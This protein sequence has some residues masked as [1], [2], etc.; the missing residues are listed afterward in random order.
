MS[1]GTPPV[2]S[3]GVFLAAD[4]E[5]WGCFRG[6]S[7]NFPGHRSA[8]G[9]ARRQWPGKDQPE[10]MGGAA[11]RMALGRWRP[12]PPPARSRKKRRSTR[13]TPRGNSPGNLG[14]KMRLRT[15]RGFGPRRW[16]RGAWGKSAEAV[17]WSR[18]GS[19]RLSRVFIFSGLSEGQA[20]RPPDG[21]ASRRM[22]LLSKSQVH[23]TKVQAGSGEGLNALPHSR[24]EASRYEDVSGQGTPACCPLARRASRAL[25]EGLNAASSVS[26]GAISKTRSL[27]R[28]GGFAPHRTGKL[29]A[30][31]PR[32]HPGFELV[33]KGIGRRP[34]NPPPTPPRNTNQ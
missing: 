17:L 7:A 8:A 9:E 25:P 12:T 29:D 13:L 11:A 27:H 26:R 15:C 20:S 28:E 31:F 18:H 33:E 21:V 32:P 19:G 16:W 3:G 6:S 14:S 2:L 5:G 4:P 10:G 22:P 30:L 23:R 34:E 1:L 24:R